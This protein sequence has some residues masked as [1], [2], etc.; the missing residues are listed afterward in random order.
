MKHIALALALSAPL[1]LSGC[2]ISV[3]DGGDNGSYQSDWQQREFNNR[4][5]IS[6]L[7][8]DSQYEDIVRKMGVADFNEMKKEGDD[9]I[10]ILFYRTQ[11]SAEDGI[12]TKDECT[13][14]VFKNNR[15][16]G[17]GDSA[18]SAL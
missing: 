3:G 10:R 4:K 12:T 17:W 14:L 9:T 2:V 7:E 18:Y 16:V 1:F 8:V 15:L 11:R 5:H 13:P 6:K